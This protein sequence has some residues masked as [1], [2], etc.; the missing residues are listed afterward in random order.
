MKLRSRGPSSRWTQTW[1]NHGPGWRG[2]R[3]SSMVSISIA[4]TTACF[5][6]SRVWPLYVILRFTSPVP[7]WIYPSDER[8]VWWATRPVEP[9]ILWTYVSSCTCILCELPDVQ[10]SDL[11]LQG[12]KTG[13]FLSTLPPHS[14]KTSLLGLS[15][16]GVMCG[17]KRV[18][19]SNVNG[20][21]GDQQA[22]AQRWYRGTMWSDKPQG[23]GYKP[24]V[25][26]LRL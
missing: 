5:T 20:G 3:D 6:A 17:W 10:Q 21:G 14:Q 23:M 13:A 25:Q 7:W 26:T 22:H 16:S 12:G 1:C 8:A 19:E 2:K 18:W 15:Y 9:Q 11:S 24:H 4:A